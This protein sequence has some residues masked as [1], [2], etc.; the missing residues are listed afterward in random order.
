MERKRLTDILHGGER[1]AIASAWQ[2]TEAAEEFAPLPAGEYIAHVTSGELFTSK[3]NHTPGYKLTFKVIEGEHEGRH[4][5]TD[6]W[7]TE[8]AIAMS[9]RDLGK[10]GVTSID[11]LEQ[12]LPQGIR[13]KAKLALRRDE[14][15]TEYNR[16]RSFEVLGI[17]EPERDAF[18]PKDE[19]QGA[20]APREDG[21]GANG[22]ASFEF[23]HNRQDA[24]KPAESAN[25]GDKSQDDKPTVDGGSPAAC[26]TGAGI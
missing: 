5:W 9:K 12:P 1:D 21:D 22:D 20:K 19:A 8:A 18:A 7:L 6:C 15:G 2:T 10:L 23:G 11:Q 4:F 3:S 17:D 25:T 26:E 14:D 13:V 16:V 24:D